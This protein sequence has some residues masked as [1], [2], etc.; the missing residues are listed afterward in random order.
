MAILQCFTDKQLI[1]KW[2]QGVAFFSPTL[3]HAL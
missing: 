3:L 2:F 1:L